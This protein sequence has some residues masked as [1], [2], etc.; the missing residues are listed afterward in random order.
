MRYV[1]LSG[2]K[3]LEVLKPQVD[4]GGYDLVLETTSVVRHIQLK[5]TFIGSK[6]RRFTVNTGLAKKPSGCVVCLQFDQSTLNLGPFYWFG[7]EPGQPLPE[8]SSFA[9]AKHTKGNAQGV[10]AP[11]PNLRVLP[12]S[13][14]EPIATI[15]KLADK[16]FG[17]K[18][19]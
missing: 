19:A 7:A 6:V 16:L 15:P 18:N 9:I 2:T 11:R 3:R 17:F 12:L 5:A 10:K 4:D 1:W 14:F 13:A 8:L